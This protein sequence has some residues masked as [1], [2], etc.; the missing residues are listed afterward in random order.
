MCANRSF[1]FSIKCTS[2]TFNLIC[3]FAC[4]KRLTRYL[5]FRFI[6]LS[7]RACSFFCSRSFLLLLLLARSSF[8]SSLRFILCIFNF[9]AAHNF[10]GFV[11]ILLRHFRCAVYV[12]VFER[13]DSDSDSRNGKSGNYIALNFS[14]HDW[15]FDDVRVHF[16]SGELFLPPFWY[17]RRC[18]F[19][20]LLFF[21][22]IHFW[23]VLVSRRNQ[24][25]KS[26]KLS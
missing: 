3:C 6:T 5:H 16:L 10:G 12:S 20:L 11:N 7:T 22:S 15:C 24:L 14:I 13:M 18:I 23:M 21:F 1:S 9:G 8:R 19:G 2:V 4:F 17:V 26:T 25:Q